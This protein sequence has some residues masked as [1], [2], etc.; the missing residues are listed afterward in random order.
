[1]QGG[2]RVEYC[3]QYMQQTEA[4]D[5]TA[6]Q[7]SRQEKRHAG[8]ISL[9][10]HR[11]MCAVAASEEE[12]KSDDDRRPERAKSPDR[13]ASGMNALPTPL[14]FLSHSANVDMVLLD[15]CVLRPGRAG[16]HK[17]RIPFQK[18]I[19]PVGSAFQGFGTPKRGQG[20]PSLKIRSQQGH[21]REYAS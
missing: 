5:R 8:D 12:R 18:L 3:L 19:F 10:R 13:V 15:S 2:G 21:Q 20:S 17:M 14:S 7:G 1:M 11:R 4:A 6:S 9:R 16:V